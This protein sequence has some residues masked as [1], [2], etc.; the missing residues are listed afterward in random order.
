FQPLLYQV[1]TAAL[2]TGDIAYPIRAVLRRQ[3]N[4]RVLL[5][6]VRSIDLAARRLELVDGSLH[7]DALL[8]ATGAS[9]SYFGRDEWAELAPGLK[10]LED[11]LQMRRRILLA[12]EAA[13]RELDPEA[14]DAWLTFVVVG[15]GPTGAELA[16][17]LAEIGR[18]TVARD[19][20]RIDPTK[21]RVLLVEAQ[22]RVL[23]GYPAELSAK[24]QAQLQSLGVE[25]RTGQRVTALDVHGVEVDGS[26][27]AARTALWA[28]GVAASPLARTLGVPLDRAGRVLVE[29]DLSVPGH[30]EVFVAGDLMAVTCGGAPVP[31][32]A[33]A[34]L[35]AGSHAAR[36]IARRLAGQPTLPFRYKH[37]GALATIGRSRAV[38]DLGRLRLAG[39]WA[40]VF[41]WLVHVFFLIGFRNRFLVMFSWAWSYLT[42]QRGARLITGATAALPRFDEGR[43]GSA[44]N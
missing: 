25:V 10:S 1:A 32:V 36:N 9:H 29:P 43:R 28:A 37:K 5:A 33:P 18:H 8:L 19:F 14:R 35:Q 27:I 34:A 11:A 42:F 20:R 13:E 40:W 4:A 44:A 26:R 24:A 41:W 3:E 22:D 23:P 38:A 30:P 39:F 31:G 12:Y 16:G 6:E 2:N 17:A 21:V 15:A 7:Y